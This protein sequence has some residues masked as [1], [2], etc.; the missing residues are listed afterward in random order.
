MYSYKELFLHFLSLIL[1]RLCFFS[2]VFSDD[3]FQELT[4]SRLVNF[5]LC[6]LKLPMSFDEK[7]VGVRDGSS[8]AFLFEPIHVKL[9]K[10]HKGGFFRNLLLD[11]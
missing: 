10:D 4:I 9:V 5:P 6:H 1:P 7:R 11:V 3:L 2:R 8:H